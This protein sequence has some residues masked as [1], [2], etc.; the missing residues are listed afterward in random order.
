[1]MFNPLSGRIEMDQMECEVLS[2]AMRKFKGFL[3]IGDNYMLQHEIWNGAL[4]VEYIPAATKILRLWN[5]DAQ[6]RYATT[7]VTELEELLTRVPEYEENL[8]RRLEMEKSVG[9][10]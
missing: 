9:G 8:R 7:M 10:R 1:M 3:R 2:A 5:I 4:R 6:Y